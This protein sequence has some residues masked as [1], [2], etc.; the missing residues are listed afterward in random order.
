MSVET[1]RR[2]AEFAGTAGTG[3]TTGEPVVVIGLSCRIPGAG[4]PAEGFDPAF[5]GIGPEAAASVDARQR[6]LLELC[7]EALEDAGIV[8]A[9]LRGAAG[10]GLFLGPDDEGGAGTECL[11][12]KVAAVFGLDGVHRTVRAGAASAPEAVHLAAESLRCGESTIALAGTADGTVVVLRPLPRA[13]AHGD[14]ILAV[15][16]ATGP[17]PEAD[18]G[19]EAGSGTAVPGRTVAEGEEVHGADAPGGGPAELP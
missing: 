19:P 10:T 13:Q 17:A 18:A 11:A 6:S 9:S 14:R 1:T 12:G 4:G 15:L 5:F 8:P 2:E 7:W 3:G 16:G